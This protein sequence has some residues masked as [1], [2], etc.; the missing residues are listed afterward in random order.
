MTAEEIWRRK[1]DAELIAA[2][3]RL[4]EYTEEGQRVIRA[5]LERRGSPDYLLEQE[6]SRP[7][8]RVTR[9]T[10][11]SRPRTTHSAAW[12]AQRAL[13][14]IGLMVGFYVFSLAIAV[15]LIAV[16]YAEWRFVGRVE[17]RLAAV[18]LGAAFTV[19]WALVPR[20]DTFEVPGP[21]LDGSAHPSLF[22]MIRQV[23]AATGQAE[24]ADVYLLNEVNAWVTHRGGT[25]GFGS[26]PVMGI[27]LPLLQA[28]SV[29][30]IKAIMAHEFGHYCAGD[31][32]LGP[33]IYKTRATI[34]RT[35]QGVRG[36]FI[37]APFV[38]YGRQFLR[39]TLAV[40]RQQ[41]FVADQVAARTVGA[42]ELASA[43]RDVTALAPVYSAYLSSEVMPA[44]QAGFLPPLARGFDEFLRADQVARTSQQI[45]DTV[46]REAETDVFDSHPSLRDRLSAL[47]VDGAAHVLEQGEA[48]ASTLI[49][50]VDG[51]ARSLVEFALGPEA[52]RK[53]KP[54]DWNLVGESVFAQ[55]WREIVRTHS[56]WL[57]QLTAD[58]LPSDRRA[59]IQLGSG[60]VGKD[61]TNV[62]SD[63]RVARAVYL[64]GA[65]IG[66]A[67]LDLGQ[68]WAVHTRPG[69]PVSLV[70]G[71]ETL[72]PFEALRGLVEGATAA[73][74][75]KA[76][77]RALG[78]TGRA[79]G[80]T[81]AV[82]A[83][84]RPPVAVAARPL[85]QLPRVG[86]DQVRCWRC[87]HA[88][89]VN[90]DNRGKTVKCPQCGTKQQLPA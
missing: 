87:K 16:P 2:S 5:E 30:Q 62:S 35:I 86:V 66:V 49:A 33:W 3:Q 32:K 15:G 11:H 79:L 14:A 29:P 18:C 58:S 60:L 7:P 74:D 50:D 4:E 64:C 41:E 26:R 68:G 63:D 36:K 21:R 42:A 78:I 43:L 46:E 54:I 39:L 20:S 71:A 69:A 48:Q 10:V 8:V 70:R 72:E 47:G 22:Q 85:E 28:L 37:E 65:G 76:K 51:Q 81:V 73:D 13:L 1:P 82:K 44:L 45:I 83:N 17:L 27:G 90:A 38:W 55:R 88:L 40:S 52:V 34:G 53:L 24:P 56:A 25:M 6:G 61:E 9:R 84:P 23:A 89:A 31:V 75:W 80:D 67:L 77:C 12:L 19:L 59:W 57:S